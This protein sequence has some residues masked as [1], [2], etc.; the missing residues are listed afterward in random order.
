MSDRASCDNTHG[1]V[2][3]DSNIRCASFPTIWSDFLIYC[4]KHAR[5]DVN[6]E[7]TSRRRTRRGWVFFSVLRVHKDQWIFSTGNSS[8]V[9]CI[10]SRLSPR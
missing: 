7:Y 9:K 4:R 10:V 3:L 2:G 6:A 1:T 8:T 5:Y